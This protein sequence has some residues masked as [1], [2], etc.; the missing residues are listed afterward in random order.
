MGVYSKILYDLIFNAIGL[1]VKKFDDIRLKTFL[2]LTMREDFG[3]GYK[4]DIKL[5]I[6]VFSQ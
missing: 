1:K 5:R 3:L 2:F 4:A 6:S